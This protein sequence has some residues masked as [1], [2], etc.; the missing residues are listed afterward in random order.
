LQGME[1]RPT[2]AHQSE[3]GFELMTV[4]LDDGSSTKP[5][6]LQAL[7]PAHSAGEHSQQA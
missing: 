1:Y 3:R 7:Q 4:T 6:L 5:V 2:L